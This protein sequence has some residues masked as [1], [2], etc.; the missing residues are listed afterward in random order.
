MSLI[1]DQAI[2]RHRI[3]SHVASD[4]IDLGDLADLVDAGATLAYG[5]PLPRQ[6][7]AEMTDRGLAAEL[8]E[9]AGPD[10]EKVA[11]LARRLLDRTRD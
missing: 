5:V 7:P 9:L 10:D 3:K 4:R 2:A 11:E 6:D 1:D 8:C